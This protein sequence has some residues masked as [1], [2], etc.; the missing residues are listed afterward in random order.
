MEIR[1]NEG[2][3]SY[4]ATQTVKIVQLRMVREK[5]VKYQEAMTNAETVVNI[6][7]PIFENIYR[8][9][10]VVIG[11]DNR[12]VPTVVHV[13]GVGIPN[14]SPVFPSSVF[15]PLLL[16]NSSG[17]ILV[18]NHPGGSNTASQADSG[19]TE[20]LVQIGKLLEI[21]LLDHLILNADGS[22]FY[23]FRTSGKLKG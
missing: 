9:Q 13:V 3:Q 20:K 21:P 12:N 8:E 1:K 16:S 4:G 10:V 6:V 17:F 2:E 22:E 5:T 11:L 14:Q 18:H 23:S 7:R 19:L 15:K